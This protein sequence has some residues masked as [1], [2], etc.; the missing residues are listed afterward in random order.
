MAESAMQTQQTRPSRCARWLLLLPFIAVLW[1][2]FYNQQEPSVFG[3]PFFYWY[4]IGW[5]LL[6]SAI[7]GF[8]Y[9]VEH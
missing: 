7:I 1:V 5:I 8:V 2:P 6:S 4:Q 3:I 9:R